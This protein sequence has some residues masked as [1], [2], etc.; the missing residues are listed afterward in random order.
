GTV[1]KL[2]PSGSGYTESV[3]HSFTGGTDGDN[4]WAGL[5]FGR[6][7]VLYGT[8]TAGGEKR[9][10]EGGT[11][12]KLTPSGSGYTESVLHSFGHA[13][14]YGS[15]ILDKEGALYG[16]ASLSGRQN[17]PGGSVFKVTP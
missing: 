7:G 5:T 15:L 12:F 1:F 14:P 8:T 6:N 17:Q 11:V 16:T 13:Y 10:H 9:R 2:T 4:P 3:L